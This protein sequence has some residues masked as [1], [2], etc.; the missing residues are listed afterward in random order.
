MRH[1]FS[2]YPMTLC[3]VAFL[4]PTATFAA[5][6]MPSA[7]VLDDTVFVAELEHGLDRL[8]DLDFAAASARFS[9]IGRRYP[10][11]PVT[12]ILGMLPTWWT[13]LLDPEETAHD[14]AMMAA[15]E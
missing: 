13:I 5:K 1:P 8:Y 15:I 4:A 3:L 12:P 6:T 10:D 2:F 11:H 7:S 9:A 14:A